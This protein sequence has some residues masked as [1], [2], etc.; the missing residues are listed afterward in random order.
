MEHLDTIA[1][2]TKNLANASIDAISKSVKYIADNLGEL[3][4]LLGTKY[5][6][7]IK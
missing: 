6:E 1:T 3:R 7:F 5:D 4:K 2:G